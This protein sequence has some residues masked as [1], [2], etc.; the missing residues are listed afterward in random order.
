MNKLHR[1]DFL[2]AGMVSSMGMVL[3]FLGM[4]YEIEFI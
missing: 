1:R 3:G 2:R 4:H